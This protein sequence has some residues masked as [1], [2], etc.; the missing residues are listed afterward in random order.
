M[1]R[2]R[3]TLA[4]AGIVLLLAAVIDI[5]IVEPRVHVRWRDDITAPQR[6][7]REQQYSLRSGE[8]L[9]DT[10]WR[11]ELH[12]RSAGNVRALID[13]D[14][15]RDTAYIDRPT[16]TVPSREIE[17]SL[18]RLVALVGP[19]PVQLVQIQS[20]L[21]IAA[22]AILVWGAALGDPVTRRTVAIG[23]LLGVAAAAYAAPLRQ[24]IRMGDADTYTATRPSFENYTGVKEIRF[25]AHLSHALLGRL[26]A[27]FDRAS[28]APT[29]AFR[30]L[31]RAGTAWFLLMG[32]TVGL[33]ESWSPV[34]LRYLGLALIGPSTLL[35]FGY[36]ELGQLSL[37]MA[38]FPLLM[39]GLAQGSPHLE[40]SAVVS[41]LASALHGFGLLSV[42]G[43]VLTVLVQRVRLVDRIRSV[44]R[45]LPWAVAAYLGW[46]VIYMIVLRLPVVAGHAEAVPLRPL[47]ADEIT[48]RVNAAV[49][50][51]RGIRDVLA[52]ILVVGMPLLIV[53]ALL[54]R[55]FSVE[56]RCALAYALPSTIFALLFW[57]IQG[58]AV[59]MDL[60]FAAFPA[61]YALAWVC[62]HDRRA[63]MT[64]AAILGCGHLIFWRIVFDSAFV[65]ARI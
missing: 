18:R 53:A 26:D 9:E 32:L 36:R 63:A 48:D 8:L 29:R 41:G 47:F 58:L 34:A 23:V 3:L 19:A 4:L 44:I 45:F 33:V 28:D 2:R 56:A 25:E 11:Y 37:N 38:A 52:T 10:I 42:A 39:R 16:L 27:I 14:A 57:P 46:I 50:S 35:F 17:V 13:D 49:L 1:R 55:R 54:W 62:A 5:D 61:V 51:G 31:M 64:A 43:S 30:A 65:N 7:E 20:V 24:P 22:G 15:V 21:L 12:D 60:V 6:I 59:E 40:A